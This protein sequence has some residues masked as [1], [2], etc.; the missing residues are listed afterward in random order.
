MG[1]EMGVGSSSPIPVPRSIRVAE[2]LWLMLRKGE[3]LA[4]D[5][6]EAV[7]ILSKHV[8]CYLKPYIEKG[9][10]V[11]RKTM[12]GRNRYSVAERLRRAVEYG[13]SLVEERLR[14]KIT[15]R[16]FVEAVLREAEELYREKFREE[17]SDAERL[18]VR[19]FAEVYF[20]KRSANP[21]SEGYISW[22]P[23]EGLG[24]IVRNM[25]RHRYGVELELDEV[26]EA[27]E[28]LGHADIIFVSK[29]YYKARL[30][31]LLLC[32]LLHH[33]GTALKYLVPRKVVERCGCA[34]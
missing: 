1:A 4:R 17:M 12:D 2:M 22:P 3:V 20:E 32:R 28:R 27:L 23:S 13:L 30:D 19:L 26:V 31:D 6:A 11:V 10:V 8:Y 9:V 18:V 21:R 24:R 29:V 16:R 5:L 25:I 15:K 14:G 33:L 7:G 34:R